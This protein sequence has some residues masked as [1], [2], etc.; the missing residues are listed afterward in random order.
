MS[1]P[2]DMEMS[3]IRT[4]SVNGVILSGAFS[5]EERRERIRVAIYQQRLAV[6]RYSDQ[7]TFAQ[8]YQRCYDRP[9]ELRRVPR[10]EH[11]RPTDF[12]ASRGDHAGDKDNPSG[13]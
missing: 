1:T 13:Q 8:A 7:L 6:E 4:L 10:D 12:L 11:Q 2:S 3:F 9:L 5:D